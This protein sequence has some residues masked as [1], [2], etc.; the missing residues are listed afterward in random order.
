MSMTTEI[1]DCMVKALKDGDKA[2]KNVY[3]MMLQAL[4]NKAKDLRVENLTPEQE[5][6]VIIKLAKQNQESI[7]TCPSDRFDVLNELRFEKKVLAQYMPKQMDKDELIPVIDDVLVEIGIE[8]ENLTAK[9]KGKIMKV[10]MPRVK[11]KADGTLVNNVLA[12]YYLNK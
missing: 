10:L 4:K 9:D 5:G 12:T 1:H 8:K 7:D 2:S 11:G 6:E 3:S